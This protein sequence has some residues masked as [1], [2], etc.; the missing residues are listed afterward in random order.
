ME[1]NIA[2]LQD[3]Y[4]EAPEGAL[5]LD[6]DGLITWMNNSATEVLK[7]DLIGMSGPELLRQ[8]NDAEILWPP[9]TKNINHRYING[10][11]MEM[12]SHKIPNNESYLITAHQLD[13]K[14]GIKTILE[15]RLADATAQTVHD[16]KTPINSIFGFSQ[17]IAENLED[18]DFSASEAENQKIITDIK[19]HIE[20][21]FNGSNSM[22][23]KIN[24]LLIIAKLEQGLAKT[25][26]E[27]I[28]MLQFTQSCI[29]KFHTTTEKKGIK[30]SRQLMGGHGHVIK[31]DRE[32]LETAIENM[33]LN[34]IE[35]LEANGQKKEITIIFGREP[36]EMISFAVT[37]PGTISPE[38]LNK[39]FKSQ[40]STKERGNGLGT[41]TIRLTAEA[42]GGKPYVKYENNLVTI[43]ISFPDAK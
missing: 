32:L 33:I 3:L 11:L 18:I 12:V 2:F 41:K 28:D 24:K 8:N 38:N 1:E 34:A 23:K 26:L 36:N 29:E 10:E 30:L 39:M 6:K 7:K 43:G 5:I 27:Q 22:V 20:V 17:L 37:N 21:V 16:L 31:A 14:N 25:N 4:Q 15:K 9:D 19:N 13:G 40:F 35:A 42:H